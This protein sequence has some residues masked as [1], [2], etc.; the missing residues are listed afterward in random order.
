M[1][2][3]FELVMLVCFG[4]SWP[5]SVYKSLTSRSTQGKSI[6]F[7]V[8]LGIVFHLLG[9][10]QHQHIG[11]DRLITHQHPKI[12]NGGPVFQVIAGAVP[13][14]EHIAEALHMGANV[15]LPEFQQQIGLNGCQFIDD[16][17]HTY[18]HSVLKSGDIHII[19]VGRVVG[20]A[21]PAVD[22]VQLE[23]VQVP[24][25]QC[26]DMPENYLVF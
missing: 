13:H 20:M 24:F 15:A 14:P 12:Q 4:L 21:P 11:V 25:F 6:V 9:G 26:P 2:Q 19:I 22:E 23:A 8:M 17:R 5:I 3:I 18:I 7:M 16:P 1:Q 10:T